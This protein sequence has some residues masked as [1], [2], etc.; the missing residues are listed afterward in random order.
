MYTN[1]TRVIK[2]YLLTHMWQ[3]IAVFK[4]NID[5]AQNRDIVEKKMNAADIFNATQKAKR[6]LKSNYKDCD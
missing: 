6:C 1:G 3:N 2:D 5:A 4:R